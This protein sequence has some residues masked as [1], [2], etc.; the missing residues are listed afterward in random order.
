MAYK[1]FESNVIPHK[2][3]QIADSV[4]KDPYEYEVVDVTINY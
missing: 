2:G 1:T 3:D 4:F